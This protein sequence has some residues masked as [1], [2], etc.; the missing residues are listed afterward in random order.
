M[1]RNYILQTTRVPFFLEWISMCK[2]TIQGQFF[3]SHMAWEWSYPASWLDFILWC[4]TTMVNPQPFSLCRIG[5]GHRHQ[6][7]TVAVAS[8]IITGVEVGGH[9]RRQAC[10]KLLIQCIIGIAICVCS[11]VNQAQMLHRT[12]EMVSNIWKESCLLTAALTAALLLRHI[13]A[14][15]S[16]RIFT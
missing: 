6:A 10:T 3:S 16:I 11:R 7:H 1:V 13:K 5:S 8:F 4:G 15:D 14:W 2:Q 12:D 9:I